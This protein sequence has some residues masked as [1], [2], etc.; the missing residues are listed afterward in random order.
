[1]ALRN[2]STRGLVLTGPKVLIGGI[3]ITGTVSKPVMVRGI[4]PSLAPFVSGSVVNPTLDLYQGDA[5]LAS[6]DDWKTDQQAEIEATGIPPA[7]D[8]ESAI[9]RTLAPG[10]YTAILRGKDNTTGIGLVE[11]YDLDLGADS[12]LANIST[13]GFVE[14]DDNVMIA[15]L[16]IGPP[17]G[18][19]APV[20]VRAIGPTLRDFG[21]SEALQ[22]PTL[23]L[24]N[25]EGAIIRS[26]NDWQDAQASEI[27]ATGLQPLDERESAVLETLTPGNYT[28]IV[29]GRGDT[30]GIAVVEVY[31]LGCQR[32]S[33]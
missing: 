13:R 18:G 7:D 30:T 4:G 31:L 2:I 28:A 20:V 8:F 10:S 5:L 27:I 9:V 25:S 29:R 24:V 3:I 32:F 12:R 23:D 22:D 1:M 11:V 14:T 21:I 19:I 16:I 33:R 6:N 26:N 15:G 17:E